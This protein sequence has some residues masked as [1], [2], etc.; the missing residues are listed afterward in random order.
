MAYFL[1]GDEATAWL[2]KRDKRMAQVIE[3]IGPVQREVVPDLFTAVAYNI[4]GQQI[5]T[6][7]LETVWERLQTMLG[8]VEPKRVA[9]ASV[10]ELQACGTTFR[11]AEYVRDFAVRVREGSFDLD[12]VAAMDDEQAIAALTELRGIG[13]WTAEMI[14][15]FSLQRPDIFA[16]DDLAIQRGLRMVYRHRDIPHERFERYRRR[17]SPYGSVA[18]LYLWAVA[19]GALPHL[20]DP[21]A[22]K[23]QG[24]R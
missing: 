13:R 1:Y 20:N 3:A 17:F 9:A 16:E 4:I 21:A 19:G 2:S 24:K 6:K 22:K 12:A 7:A 11:K 23:R 18:S 10:E 14:L 5:S 15:L 8:E